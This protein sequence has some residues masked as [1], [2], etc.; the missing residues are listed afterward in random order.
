VGRVLCVPDNYLPQSPHLAP[1]AAHSQSPSA[2][3]LPYPPHDSQMADFRSTPPN[4]SSHQNLDALTLRAIGRLGDIFRQHGV[5]YSPSEAEG[6]MSIYGQKR[7]FKDGRYKKLMEKHITIGGGDRNNCIQIYFEF[8]TE[9]EKVDIG[10]C[11]FHLPYE[12]Q[13]T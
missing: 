7:E 6:T 12:T 2:H 3:G 4:H 9:L 5:K 10:Y 8:D 11:G 1:S 13:R